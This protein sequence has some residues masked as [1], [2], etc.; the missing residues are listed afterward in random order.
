MDTQMNND[1]AAGFNPKDPAAAHKALAEGS[2][3]GRVSHPK[4]VATVG[5]FLLLDAP[6]QMTGALVPVDGGRGAI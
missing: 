1:T 3:T 4:E 2:P 5:V 6:I